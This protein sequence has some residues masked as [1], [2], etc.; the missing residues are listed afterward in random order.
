MLHDT[1]YGKGAVAV[2]KTYHGVFKLFERRH[3]LGGT[4]PT[5]RNVFVMNPVSV[6]DDST[7][8]TERMGQTEAADLEIA[9]GIQEQI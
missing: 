2:R 9:V 1:R 8:L 3:D 6:P 7:V 5:R 4:I